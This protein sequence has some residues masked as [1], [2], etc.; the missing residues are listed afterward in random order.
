MSH[1]SHKTSLACAGAFAAAAAI[2]GIGPASAHTVIGQRI[3][4][5]TLTID[6]PGVNDELALPTFNYMFLS[7]TTYPPVDGAQVY[8][9]NGFYGKRITADLEVSINDS[10]IHQ[11]NPRLNGWTVIETE[12]RDQIMVNT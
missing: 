1:K 6:D 10:F 2:A 8:T 12:V 7:S 9:W 3:F 4:P 5:V 11:I